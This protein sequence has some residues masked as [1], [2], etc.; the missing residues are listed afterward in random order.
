MLTPLMLRT[1]LQTFCLD[2]IRKTFD[3]R[4]GGRHCIFLVPTKGEVD[5]EVA[6]G[7]IFKSR[8]DGLD[9]DSSDV[10]FVDIQIEVNGKPLAPAV[11]P[12]G[13]PGGNPVVP[14]KRGWARLS[15][16]TDFAELDNGSGFG[17]VEASVYKSTPI[18]DTDYSDVAVREAPGAMAYENFRRGDLVGIWKI[19][20]IM[21]GALP[22]DLGS[23]AAEASNIGQS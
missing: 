12:T 21:S 17:V 16:R 13:W 22:V 14:E 2:P 6:T 11:I 4:G 5:L 23:L 8:G 3:E 7:I 1:E 20:L 18:G 15:T 9:L 19:Y 10:K